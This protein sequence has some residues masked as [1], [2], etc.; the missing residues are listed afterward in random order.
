MSSLCGSKNNPWKFGEGKEGREGIQ[1]LDEYPQAQQNLGNKFT[2]RGR[3]KWEK[4]K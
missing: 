3:F 2:P 4:K 1:V